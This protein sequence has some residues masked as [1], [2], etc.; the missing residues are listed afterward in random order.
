[1]LVYTEYAVPPRKSMWVAEVTLLLKETSV[2][3]TQGSPNSRAKFN[4]TPFVG[5][6]S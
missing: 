6:P 5:F 3:A 1:M 4:V 2:T